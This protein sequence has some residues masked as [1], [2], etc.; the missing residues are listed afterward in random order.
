MKILIVIDYQKDFVDGALGFSGAE[1]LDERIAQRVREYGGGRVFYTLDTHYED[2]ADTLEGRLL[3]VS[4]CI[5]GTK[6]HELYGETAAALSE[7]GAEG[8]EKESFGLKIT[9]E[10]RKKLP[11]EVEE[12]ELCGL[13][14]N[15]CVLSAAVVFRTEYPNA[16]ITVDAS[17]TACA[18]PALN[19][20][21]LDVMEGLQV[22]VIR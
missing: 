21:A 14:S 8:F 20:K 3:P 19:E 18:D 6:G 1:V 4:H 5:K 7:V 16:Q 11:K 12:I 15:I 2:Y 9:D 22:R 10:I 13:V 17:L